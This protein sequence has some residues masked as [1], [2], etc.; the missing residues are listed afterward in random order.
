MVT[1]ENRFVNA[2]KMQER[3]TINCTKINFAGSGV[4]LIGAHNGAKNKHS[5][6]HFSERTACKNEPS[7]CTREMLFNKQPDE[8]A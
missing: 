8:N 4:S 5:K 3:N 1:Q 2:R 7:K 6:K